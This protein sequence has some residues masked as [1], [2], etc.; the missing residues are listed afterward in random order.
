M[1]NWFPTNGG[2]VSGYSDTNFEEL[3]AKYLSFPGLETSKRYYSDFVNALK[4][5]GAPL[6][7]IMAYNIGD[8]VTFYDNK[9]PLSLNSGITH[10][11]GGDFDMSKSNDRERMIDIS[12]V[13]WLNSIREVI[14]SLDTDSL[15]TAQYFDPKACIINNAKC[16]VHPYWPIADAA[17]GGSSLDFIGLSMYPDWGISM[18]QMAIDF[19]IPITHQK[20]IIMLENSIKRNP[21][22]S[23]APQTILNWQVASCSIGITGWLYWTW[24]TTEQNQLANSGDWITAVKDPTYGDLINKTL[25]PKYRSDP[26]SFNI[27]PTC[28]T[29]N[30]SDWDN[31]VN[32]IQTRTFTGNPANC[33]DD[34]QLLTQSCASPMVTV[35]A[36][37][38][39][40][41]GNGPIYNVPGE[42]I[43]LQYGSPAK[44]SDQTTDSNGQTNFIISRSDSYIAVR[45]GSNSNSG[46]LAQ[47]NQPYSLM[48]FN[49][50][51]INCSNGN[52]TQCLGGIPNASGNFCG[53]GNASYEVCDLKNSDNSGPFTFKLSNCGVPPV[54]SSSISSS[55]VS[56]TNSSSSISSS[57]V[58]SINSSSSIS[59]SSV[60]SINF[61][62]SISSSSSIH[63]SSSINGSIICGLMDVSNKGSIDIIDFARFARIYNKSCS[64]SY[65]T[66][67]NSRC[68]PMDTNHDGKI[69]IIDFANF[70]R[71]YGKSC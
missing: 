70:A 60:S 23:T 32:N 58:S 57:S 2:Y 12:S 20:P 46:I 18:T 5:T 3:N 17:L 66:Y 55:S 42:H 71:K 50:G 45:L 64:D 26:C 25:S 38:I 19:Q 47:T 49:N 8:E 27:N 31:C 29:T 22:S 33:V 65:S 15:I 43:T 62:S 68:G 10:S 16:E 40:Q 13:I 30:Y 61:S 11:I 48:S 39:C 7:A 6:G 24:D 34:P 51:A 1:G 21:L 54:S 41:D 35:K 56:S 53:S 9:K 37:V 52:V 59:S 4:N 44:L 69:D 14:K 63:S 67:L 28:T 36:N